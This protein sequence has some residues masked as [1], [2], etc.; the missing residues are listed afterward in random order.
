MGTTI[1]DRIRIAFNEQVKAYLEKGFLIDPYS[2]HDRDIPCLHV[3]LL[4][5][6]TTVRV[7]IDFDDM[8]NYCVVVGK[9]T[10]GF[11][12]RVWNDQLTE[13]SRSVIR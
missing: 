12:I 10:K 8:R 5:N 1:T 3:D 13:V 9:Y 2:L 6:R 4:K 11:A 7:Y